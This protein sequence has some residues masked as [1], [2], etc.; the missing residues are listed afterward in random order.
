[1]LQPSCR[2]LHPVQR[3]LGTE[4]VVQQLASKYVVVIVILHEKDPYYFVRHD[5][6][7]A[8]RVA[9]PRY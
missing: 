4:A 7:R 5:W 3:E 6:A 9:V 1:M 8:P 2:V